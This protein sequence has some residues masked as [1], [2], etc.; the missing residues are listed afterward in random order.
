MNRLLTAVVALTVIVAAPAIASAQGD[1][2]EAWN[3]F[4]EGSSVTSETAMEMGATKNKSTMKLTLKKKEAD[5][6]TVTIETEAMGQKNSMDQTY[7][8]VKKAV[9]CPACKKEHKAPAFKETGKDKVKIGDKE[10]DV[11]CWELTNYGCADAESKSTACM[12]KEV[13]GALVK[14]TTKTEQ[15]SMTMTVTA[16]EKK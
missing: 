7:E 15:Y 12:S 11:T 4:G 13:P 5:K 14:M 1:P 16:F 10:Y 9:E 3:G 8:K 2:F 6:I